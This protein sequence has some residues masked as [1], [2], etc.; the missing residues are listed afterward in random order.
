MIDYCILIFLLPNKIRLITVIQKNIQT[1][2]IFLTDNDKYRL[3]S[4]TVW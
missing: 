3:A 1:E 4:I 2:D